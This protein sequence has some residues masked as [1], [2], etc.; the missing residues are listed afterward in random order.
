MKV[1]TTNEF[2]FENELV[3]MY[4]LTDD[5]GETSKPDEGDGSVETGEEEEEEGEIKPYD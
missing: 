5:P 4:C 1:K 3:S 2:D